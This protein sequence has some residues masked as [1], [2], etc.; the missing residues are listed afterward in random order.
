MKIRKAVLPVAGLG[1]R[2]L[3]ATKVVPKELFPIIDKPIIEIIIEELIE[4]GIESFLLIIRRGKE[5][6][7]QHFDINFELEA[8]LIETN[9][10]DF[11]KKIQKTNL[12]NMITLQK[13]SQPL[14]FAN[15]IMQA[16]N[17]VHNEPFILCTGDELIQNNA[18]SSIQQLIECYNKFNKSI[19]G[20]SYCSDEE[21]K[22]YGVIDCDKMDGFLN[23]NNII[24]K[25]QSNAPSNFAINGKYLMQSDVFNCLEKLIVSENQK[26]LLFTDCLLELAKKNS[27]IG[28]EI[29]GKRF[30]TGN[31]LGYIKANIEYAL[32]DDSIGCKLR[33][34]LKE[35]YYEL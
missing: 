2:F 31:K 11:L 35:L 16:K 6:I 4:A 8:N 21:L 29:Q 23:I 13:Q 30:D 18:V 9:K 27:L 14:G 19:V 26:E 1:T 10:I 28:L 34:Y 15:A 32:R 7:S 24:E 33:K 12:A 20:V 5:I 3:P 22:E 17:F 25:P